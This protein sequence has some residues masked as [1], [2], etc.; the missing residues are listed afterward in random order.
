MQHHPVDYFNTTEGCNDEMDSEEQLITRR[1]KL[2]HQEIL[3]SSQA[4]VAKRAGKPDRQI[5]DMVNGRKSFGDSVAREIGPKIRP[6]LHRDWLIFADEELIEEQHVSSLDRRIAS[7][8][9]ALIQDIVK[10]L[11]A[12]N[13]EGLGTVYAV[14]K[15]EAERHPLINQLSSCQ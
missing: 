8:R 12:T 11:R 9:E 6:D 4:D 2:L 1:R 13:E 3:R 5:A 15:L 10:L 14:S 7:R